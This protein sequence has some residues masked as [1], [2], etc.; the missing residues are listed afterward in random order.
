MLAADLGAAFGAMAAVPPVGGALNKASVG[1]WAPLRATG[2]P[3]M[4]K[5]AP[6]T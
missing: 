1:S 2:N 4:T 3:I 5:T 6:L